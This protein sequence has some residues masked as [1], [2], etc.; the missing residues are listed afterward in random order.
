[1]KMITDI[2]ITAEKISAG[3]FVSFFLLL[4]CFFAL[5]AMIVGGI[6]RVIQAIKNRLY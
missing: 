6:T 3:V 2:L 5:I 4:I 1:M